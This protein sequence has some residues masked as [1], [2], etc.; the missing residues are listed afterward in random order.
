ME[1]VR[2]AGEEVEGDEVGEQEGD[3]QRESGV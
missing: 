3:E 2:E 1:G